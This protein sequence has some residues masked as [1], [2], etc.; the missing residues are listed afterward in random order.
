M[1]Y[2]TPRRRS[3][4]ANI[5]V[6]EQRADDHDDAVL[7]IEAKVDL[8]VKTMNQNVGALSLGNWIV[9]LLVALGVVSWAGIKIG[10]AVVK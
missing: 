2:D 6:L 3:Y 7:R 5:A 1:S 8:L 9:K 4:D 10:A